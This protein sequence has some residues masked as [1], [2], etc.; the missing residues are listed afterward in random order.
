MDSV[1]QWSSGLFIL[2]LRK[3]FIYHIYYI[4]PNGLIAKLPRQGDYLETNLR[5]FLLFLHKSS[6]CYDPSLELSRQ[7]SFNEGL[8][9]FYGEVKKDPISTIYPG[10]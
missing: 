1:S 8:K 9:S 6:I 3:I 10:C 4:R 2:N 5:S 7:G